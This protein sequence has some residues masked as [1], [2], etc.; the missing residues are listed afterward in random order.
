MQPTKV[1]VIGMLDSIHVGRWLSQFED[2]NTE[3]VLFPSKK[4]RNIN[5]LTLKLLK[6]ESKVKV[7]VYANR[8]PKKMLGYF[9]YLTKVIPVRMNFNSR[10]LS[11]KRAIGSE[12]F[13]FIH[14][15]EIQ[16]AGYLADLATPNSQKNGAKLIL[17]NWGSDIYYF[18]NFPDHKR[19]IISALKKADYY[20][21][22]CERD[23]SL[24]NELGFSGNPLPCIPNAGGFKLDQQIGILPSNRR[25]IVVKCYGGV[26]GRGGL[27]LEALEQVLPFFLDYRVFLYSVTSDLESRVLELKE[28]FPDRIT[29]ATQKKPISRELI[30]DEF[31]NSRV[32]IGASVSDGISTS[33]LEALAYGAFPIQTDTS[34]ANEWI[35]RGA[36]GLTPK[37]EVSALI[38]SLTTA[39][40][41]NH[42]VDQ[43]QLVNRK[44]VLSEINSDKIKKVAKSFYSMM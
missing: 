17:T 27:I 37:L 30:L 18:Q 31:A 15:L 34:C 29:Y 40:I 39:L 2:T 19:Q 42:L 6:K 16:G 21:A 35:I 44:I 11:L 28:R 38:T 14:A 32:Y 9:D 33:F 8:T 13:D 10:V 20:S 12:N 1:L 23:Y 4:F 43:A 3:F 5:P 24:A 36:V 7:R 26:F 25:Q 41:D 22:E